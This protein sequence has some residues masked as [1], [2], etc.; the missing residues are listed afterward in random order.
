MLLQLGF[1][2]HYPNFTVGRRRGCRPC[3]DRVRS[4]LHGPLLLYSELLYYTYNAPDTFE[5]AFS[6]SSVEVRFK[7]PS[8]RAQFALSMNTAV[9]T[10]LEGIERRKEISAELHSLLRGAEELAPVNTSSERST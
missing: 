4:R 2:W 6:T 5:W 3:G 9:A 8:I 1:R 10:S 7:D